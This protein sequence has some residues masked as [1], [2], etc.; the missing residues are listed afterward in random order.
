[1]PP[2]FAAFGR[3][4]FGFTKPRQ[5]ILGVELS[6]IVDAVGAEVRT[7]N[8]GDAVIAFPDT[9]MG[10]HAEYHC[11]KADGLVVPKPA[12][13]AFEQAAAI[14][15][16]GMTMHGFYARAALVSGQRVLVNGA[17]GTVGSAAVQLARAAGA[18]VTAVCSA[19]NAAL[20]QSIGAQHVIDYHAQDFTA[21]GQ[22]WDVIVDTVG[23]APYARVRR[24]LTER[25]RLLAV[26]NSLGEL[27]AAPFVGLRSS[28]RV[29]VGPS[30]ATM[31]DLQALADLAADGTFVPLIDRVYDFSSIVEAHRRV[32]SG[33]KRGSVVIAVS[34]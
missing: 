34:V 22:R 14:C 15:F 23:N 25:G 24:A 30:T 13:L 4:A 17:S 3:L 20:V 2:G 8:V 5:P 16:G 12:H 21:L 10:A 19:A 6:G 28:H 7:F 32:D 27:I 29:I 9:A 1:M 26:L 18:E 31:D 11:M 33:R